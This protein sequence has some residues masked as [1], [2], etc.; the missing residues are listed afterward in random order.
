VLTKD[1]GVNPE[2][3]GWI[4]MPE[5]FRHDMDRHTSQ[6]K[7]RGMNLPQING[8]APLGEPAHRAGGWHCVPG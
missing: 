8:V 6:Q 7:V 2:R 4:G 1:V 5:T 3:D